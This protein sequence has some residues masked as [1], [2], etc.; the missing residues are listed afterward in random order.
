MKRPRIAPRTPQAATPS[1][2][3]TSS[4]A[5]VSRDFERGGSTTANIVRLTFLIELGIVL[6]YLENPGDARMRTTPIND[7][8]IQL[9]MHQQERHMNG[10]DFVD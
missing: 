9:T 8:L 1:A 10:F 4:P 5:A 2:T 7:N 3:A 6:I